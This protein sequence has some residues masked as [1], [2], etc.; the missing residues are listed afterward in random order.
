MDSE[1]ALDEFAVIARDKTRSGV[2]LHKSGDVA[3]A[4]QGAAKVMRTE[5][6]TRY[7]YHAQMEPLN[8]TAAVVGRWQIG[9]NLGRY[10]EHPGLVAQVAGMLQTDLAT[11]SSTSNCS[12]VGLAAVRRITVV[13]DA[14]R[15]SKA[16]GK[17]V[18]L[19]W[20]REDDVRHG[21]FVHRRCN[22]S[23][24]G[25][26]PTARSSPGTIGWSRNRRCAS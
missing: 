17:P 2:D 10:P 22:T 13:H 16:V 9:G 19:V 24:P 5:F 26:T 21:K 15:L 3:A 25:S 20:S 23:R 18:K 7:V 11:S 8:A 1:R 6:R 4:M 12:A 14:V